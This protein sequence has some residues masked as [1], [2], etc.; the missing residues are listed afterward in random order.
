MLLKHEAFIEINGEKVPIAIQKHAPVEV[1]HLPPPPSSICTHHEPVGHC[2]YCGATNQ[3][4][5]EHIIPYGLSGVEVLPKASCADCARETCKFEQEVLRGPMRAARIHR[6]LK[7]RT[8]HTD[9]PLTQRA[10]LIRESGE[11][12]IDLPLAEYP[13]LL[14]FP[15]FAQPGHLT[16]RFGTGITMTGMVTVLFGPT[17]ETVARNHGALEIRFPQSPMKPVAFARMIAKIGLGFAVAGG[18]L[19]SIEGASPVASCINGSTDDVGQWVFTDGSNPIRI[20]GYLHR[21]QMHHMNGFLIAEVH[22]FA[23]SG[24]PKYGVVLG[25]LK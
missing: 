3:L 1:V 20:P 10:T 17:P 16:G 11:E 15:T 23:D 12:E 21:V 9:G 4:S 18:C 19:A 7:S 8:K 22:L 14:H 24:A 13:I 25:K 2:I 5:D 6:K